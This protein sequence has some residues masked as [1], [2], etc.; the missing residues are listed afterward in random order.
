MLDAAGGLPKRGCLA[1]VPAEAGEVRHIEQVEH[2]A[3]QRQLI[4]FLEAEAAAESPAGST[5]RAKSE[6]RSV[7]G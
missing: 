5:G 1:Q 6:S 3:E 7:S 4:A 2:L